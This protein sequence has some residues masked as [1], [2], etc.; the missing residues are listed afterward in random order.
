[1]KTSMQDMVLNISSFQA[2]NLLSQKSRCNKFE[3]ISAISS[4]Y[5]NTSSACTALNFNWQIL[6]FKT[7]GHQVYERKTYK[8]PEEV[9]SRE[10]LM[11]T[12]SQVSTLAGQERD[13]ILYSGVQRRFRSVVFDVENYII[14]KSIFDW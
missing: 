11:T 9:W 12:V 6:Y 1:M 13:G 3:Q 2:T 4:K 7:V 14:Y 10:V 5:F 8:T